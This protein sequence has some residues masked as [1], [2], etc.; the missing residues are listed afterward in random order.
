MPLSSTSPCSS[1]STLILNTN[2][3]TP[4]TVTSTLFSNHLYDKYPPS[5]RSAIWD[6]HFK[7]LPTS[8]SLLEAEPEKNPQIAPCCCQVRPSPSSSPS[9][10]SLGPRAIVPKKLRVQGY[11]Y[12][13]TTF[14]PWIKLMKRKTVL[15]NI[16]S[17][18]NWHS[19]T[20]TC[21][22]IILNR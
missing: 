19:S 10:L 20:Q 6:D 18:R 11:L 7:D 17:A 5:P 1:D 12:V 2:F 21:P 3:H 8:F 13:K 16:L 4:S 22:T 15:T 9:S 14:E